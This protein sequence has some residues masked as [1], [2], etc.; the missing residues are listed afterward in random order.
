MMSMNFEL[1]YDCIY[2][3]R[4]MHDQYF[5]GEVKISKGYF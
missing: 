4:W 1:A 5:M 2:S 3:Q